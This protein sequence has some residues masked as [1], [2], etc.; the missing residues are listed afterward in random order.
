MEVKPEEK[1]IQE[2]PIHVTE[3][4][5]SLLQVPQ[6]RHHPQEVQMGYGFTYPCCPHKEGSRVLLLCLQH[7]QYGFTPEA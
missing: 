6:L 2:K 5:N 7:I 4:E 1:P 3:G